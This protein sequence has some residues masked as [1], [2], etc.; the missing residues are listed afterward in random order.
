MKNSFLVLVAMLLSSSI[1]AQTN[2]HEGHKERCS[3]MY[4]YEQ[5]KLMDPELGKK[6]ENFEAA[7]SKRAINNRGTSKDTTRLIIPVVVHVI[8]HTNSQN[9]SM[10]RVNQQIERLNHDYRKTNNDTTDIPDE[11][12]P[13]AADCEIEFAMA[14]VDPN[15]APTDG[16]TRTYTE[17]TSYE[18]SYNEWI[19]HAELGGVDAWDTDKYLNIWVC[20]MAGG[21]LGYAQFPYETNASEDGVVISYQYF[22]ETYGSYDMGRTATHEVGHWLGLYHIWGDDGG[23][24][25]GSDNVDDTPNQGDNYWGTPS[26]PQTSCESNDMFMNYMDYVDDE[27]MIMFTEGQSTRIWSSIETYRSELGQDSLHFPLPPLPE[28]FE[29]SYVLD[30]NNVTLSWKYDA[31]SSMFMD[32]FTGFNIYRN[33]LLIGTLADTSIR[34]FE[35]T[36]LL[37]DDYVYYVKSIFQLVNEVESD[38]SN[39]VLVFVKT[40]FPPQNLTASLSESSVEL[41]W[42]APAIKGVL[43]GYNIYRDNDLLA[44]SIS[45]E[46]LSYLDDSLP[47]NT[48]HYYLQSFDDLGSLSDTSNNVEVEV[49]TITPDF[50]ASATEIGGGSTV[51]F[52]DLTI[53]NVTSY[54][55][56]FE[57]GIAD[58]PDVANPSVQYDSMGVYSVELTV[59]NDFNTKSVFKRDY[60]ICKWNVNVPDL[61]SA[62]ILIYPNPAK[63][64]I[65]IVPD[66][67]F[68]GEIIVELYDLSGKCAFRNVFT[69]T[70]K[71]TINVSDMAS[72]MYTLVIRDNINHLIQKIIV[73]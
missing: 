38:S 72:G 49:L 70:T 34:T 6:Q 2:Q 60:I 36:N 48:Y 45:T 16:V 25:S 69:N 33:D 55:W 30:F 66:H 3:I 20:N 63:E 13:Y 71:L 26:H 23:A 29:L 37:D 27:A 46:Q 18:W 24:C 14:G 4:V 64:Y 67:N 68:E 5:K 73:K 42:E 19:K 28:P 31:D 65:N 17:E 40:L 10:E 53:G 54:E 32:D 22:G 61:S 8:W 58:F 21:I 44:D 41:N 9:I 52:T 62:E 1:F 47:D 57:G 39:Q 51:E 35:D 59:T 15:G 43:V 7:L 56:D 50:V 11:F 12:R